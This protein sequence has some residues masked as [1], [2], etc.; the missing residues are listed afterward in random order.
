MVAKEM[1]YYFKLRLNKIDSQ[2]YRNIKVPQLDLLLNEAANLLIKWIAQPRQKDVRGFELSHRNIEDLH[3]IVVDN[4][5]L[6][7]VADGNNYKAVLPN[8]YKFHVSSKVDMTKG[9]CT[10]TGIGTTQI[11]HD[12]DPLFFGSSSFEWEDVNIRFF[13]GGIKILSEGEFTVN[14][15]YLDYIKNIAYIHNAESFNATTGYKNFE[16]VSLTGSQNCELPDHLHS[17]II[18]LAVLIASG[19]LELPNYQVMREKLE[20]HN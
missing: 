11:Q 5:S 12:D 15:F 6:S 7:V 1:L 13:D 17:E 4:R 9:N 10:K 19:Q 2:Q 16:G 14:N 8:D 3:T 18:D 20:L